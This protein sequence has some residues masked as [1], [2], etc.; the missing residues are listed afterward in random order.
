ETGNPTATLEATGDVTDIDPAQ[1]RIAFAKTLERTLTVFDP[2]TGAI[3]M[4]AEKLPSLSG[5]LEFSPDGKLLAW[6]GNNGLVR[7]WDVATG[8]QVLSF[9]P[10]KASISALLFTPDGQ[11]LITGSADR[12]VKFWD[13]STGRE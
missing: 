4:R 6:S 13:L 10:H 11:Q 3:L 8:A 7:L 1:G 5:H 12:T 9:Q 2:A